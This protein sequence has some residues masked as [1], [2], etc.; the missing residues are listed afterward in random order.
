MG[1][2]VDEG[3]RWTGQI[4]QVRA[5]VG[6]LLGVLGRA[7]GV[8]GGRSLLSL[9]NGLILPHLQYCL[10]VCGD[11]QGCR[12]VTLGNA[13]LQ[14]QKRAAGWWQERMAGIM[15][16]LSLPSMGC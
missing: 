1:V 3:L 16:I 7:S 14:Y 2:W 12:N 8:L 5:K 11:F 4:G 10:M 13:L 9:Y 6:Q 15:L